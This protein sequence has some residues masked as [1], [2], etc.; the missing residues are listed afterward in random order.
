MTCLALLDWRTRSSILQAWEGKR[1]SERPPGSPD[2]QRWGIQP[3][4]VNLQISCQTRTLKK[5]QC[6]ATFVRYFVHTAKS[7]SMDTPH[8]TEEETESLL[9]DVTEEPSLPSRLLFFPLTCLLLPD[10]ISS[11]RGQTCP[12]R[13]PPKPSLLRNLCSHPPLVS[14]PPGG[15]LVMAQ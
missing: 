8:F 15:L 12:W 5:P 4:T 1:F 6:L 7:I 2:K 14:P 3:G 10:T 13:P 11:R 9:N